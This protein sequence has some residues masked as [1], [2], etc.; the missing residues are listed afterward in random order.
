[1]R[2]CTLSC[3][4]SQANILQFITRF[5]VFISSGASICTHLFLWT[6]RVLKRAMETTSHGSALFVLLMT[7][8]YTVCWHCVSTEEA[9]V[10]CTKLS[11]LS[12]CSRGSSFTLPS[13]SRVKHSHPFSTLITAFSNVII[14]FFSLHFFHSF[15]HHTQ[16]P[17]LVC[18]FP[19]HCL[20][21][22]THH[23]LST[24][25]RD[26]VMQYILTWWCF[27]TFFVCSSPLRGASAN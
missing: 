3:E 5:E 25:K 11:D 20:K 6:I 22:E 7:K 17:F 10:Y 1:M 14:F 27:D 16:Y 4:S 2:S 24:D 9:H 26:S 8:H 21:G 13:L 12:G 23:V 18:Q 19:N 15:L